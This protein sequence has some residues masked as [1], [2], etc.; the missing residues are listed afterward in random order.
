MGFEEFAGGFGDTQGVK[1]NQAQ[2]QRAFALFD[3]PVG[4]AQAADMGL[5]NIH[6]HERFHYGG[7]ETAADGSLFNGHHAIES[8]RQVSQ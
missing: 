3:E 8:L 6:I 2:Q 5:P 4:K 7:A 1:T